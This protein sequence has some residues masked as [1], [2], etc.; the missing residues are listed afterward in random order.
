ME[1]DA[2]VL[3]LGLDED[4]EFDIGTSKIVKKCDAVQTP[5]ESKDNAEKLWDSAKMAELEAELVVQCSVAQVR[6]NLYQ[7]SEII[8]SAGKFILNLTF[9]KISLKLLKNLQG[10]HPNLSSHPVLLPG[11]LFI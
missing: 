1:S 7:R 11:V 2:D 6:K 10:M 9:F 3:D 5:T 4:N 8:A